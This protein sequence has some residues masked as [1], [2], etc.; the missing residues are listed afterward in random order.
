MLIIQSP[1]YMYVLILI[2]SYCFIYYVFSNSSLAVSHI[3][4]HLYLPENHNG[5][6]DNG[7]L[8]ITWFRRPGWYPKNYNMSKCE[9]KNCIISD[10]QANLNK[11][12]AVLYSYRHLSKN[13]PFKPKNQY[14][15][16]A[17]FECP[18]SDGPMSR[19]WSTQFDV[20]YSYLHDSD[21][22]GTIPNLELRSKIL[23]KNYSQIFE[24][25]TNFAAWAVSNCKTQSRRAAYINKL[26]EYGV[27][28]DVYGGCGNKT[29]CNHNTNKQCHILLSKRYKFY[30]AFE[31]SICKDYVTEKFANSLDESHDSLIIYRGAPNVREIFPE[32]IYIKTL[33]FQ[34]VKSLAEY[35]L[36]VGSSEEK[37]TALL[38]QKHRYRM[39]Y[40][41]YYC[42]FCEWATN[43]Q[44]SKP[45]HIKRDFNEWFRTNKCRTVHT[46][47]V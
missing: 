15:I 39:N 37:Y 10:D 27:G 21:I 14:W 25:K 42:S 13:I 47:V 41:N 29:V 46:D 35:L 3:K 9:Y 45:A 44:K 11:S 32:K 19:R 18:L 12:Y 20:F 38:K 16:I 24:V 34:N 33:D 6:N 17:N 2:V 30:L 31:S 23:E 4:N 1:V 5:T 40:R 43:S 7:K 36:S 8:L 26:K 28:V 22:M